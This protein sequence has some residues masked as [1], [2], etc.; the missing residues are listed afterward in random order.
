MAKVAPAGNQKGTVDTP[1]TDAPKEVDDPVALAI[2]KSC[3]KFTVIPLII[4]SW[5][6]C[7]VVVLLADL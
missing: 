1:S 4:T 2:D 7:K 5:V 3:V 6:W